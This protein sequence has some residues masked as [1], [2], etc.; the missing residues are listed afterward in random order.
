LTLAQEEKTR[1][2][3]PEKKAYRDG[4]IPIKDN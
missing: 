1:K 3:K 2:R 4:F